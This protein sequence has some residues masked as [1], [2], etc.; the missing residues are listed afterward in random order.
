M[1]MRGFF[2]YLHKPKHKVMNKWYAAIAVTMGICIGLRVSSCFIEVNA[3]KVFSIISYIIVASIML[4][5]INDI[6]E[7][8]VKQ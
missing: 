7:E 8:N 3:E 4:Y 5:K 6:K 2:V 1:S